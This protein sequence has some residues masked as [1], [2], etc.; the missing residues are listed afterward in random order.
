MPNGKRLR[1]GL[2]LRRGSR[3][4]RVKLLKDQ[5]IHL[6]DEE[7]GEVDRLSYLDWE[8]GCYEGTIQML[9]DP[10]AEL[11]PS[12]HEVMKVE[13]S[14]LPDTVRMSVLHKD[15]YISA[16]LDPVG[17]YER[18]LPDVPGDQ[19]LIPTS[20]TRR[21]LV[22][23]SNMVLDVFIRTHTPI[24]M[25]VFGKSK[26]K[27]F[28]ENRPH[29]F[30]KAPAFSTYCGWITQWQHAACRDKR[31]LASRYDNGQKAHLCENVR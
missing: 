7:T 2:Y 16:F 1:W 27:T 17:F 23:F 25:E 29:D 4:W 13:V 26:T 5:V 8:T 30:D 3:T 20:R 9:D 31:L 15:F 21:E 14:N 28:E 22:P 12:Q 11:T 24:Y 10:T 6:V 18:H 19:R